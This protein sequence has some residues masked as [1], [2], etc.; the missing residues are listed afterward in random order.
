MLG[1]GAEVIV[2]GNGRDNVA[3]GV[4]ATDVESVPAEGRGAEVVGTVCLWENLALNG[5]IMAEEGLAAGY[6]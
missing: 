4:D 3:F 1:G 5:E 2:A 6:V